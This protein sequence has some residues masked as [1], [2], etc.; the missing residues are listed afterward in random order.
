MT[1]IDTYFFGHPMSKHQSL[2]AHSLTKAESFFF[3]VQRY[4][5]M[6]YFGT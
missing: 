3:N 2:P 4:T 1:I 5:T 6:N